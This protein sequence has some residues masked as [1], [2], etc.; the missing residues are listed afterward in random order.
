MKTSGLPWAI[1]DPH[2]MGS[3]ILATGLLFMY[4]VDEPMAHTPSWHELPQQ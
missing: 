2:V 4:T 1:T 3:P